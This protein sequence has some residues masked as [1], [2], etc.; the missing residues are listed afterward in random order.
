MTKHGKS[1]STSDSKKFYLYLKS[2]CICKN[3]EN[4]Y[5]CS[6]NSSIFSKL[7]RRFLSELEL[8][9]VEPLIAKLNE[10]TDKVLL[11]SAMLT[12]GDFE[13]IQ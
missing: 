1:D 2:I 6:L 8:D 3:S 10:T 11:I 12:K 4:N 13:M 5:C 9:F 7:T